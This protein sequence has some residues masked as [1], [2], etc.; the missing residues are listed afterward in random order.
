MSKVKLT[1]G[2]CEAIGEAIA[3]SLAP[4]LERLDKLE[5]APTLKFGG[6]W[7]PEK[8]YSAGDCVTYAGGLWHGNIAT[9]GFRP[10]T[11]SAW[12]LAVKRGTR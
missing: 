10:G 4:L 2:D 8:S 5:S 3:K 11:G 1:E 6:T 12:T 9:K 7:K